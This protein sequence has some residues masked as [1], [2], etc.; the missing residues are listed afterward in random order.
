MRC[1]RP[2]RAT[3]PFGVI[4]FLSTDQPNDVDKVRVF[5]EP[6]ERWMCYDRK[7]EAKY[8]NQAFRDERI[9]TA[10]EK[11]LVR[12]GLCIQGKNTGQFSTARSRSP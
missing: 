3:S 5:R 6:S 10:P 8:T 1:D 4:P 11:L 2:D 12:R 7:L 9:F